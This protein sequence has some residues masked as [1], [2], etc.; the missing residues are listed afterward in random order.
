MAT[1]PSLINLCFG[2][3]KT[4]ILYGNDDGILEGIYELPVELFDGL[5]NQLPALALH[6]LQLLMPSETLNNFHFESDASG[7]GRKR[8]RCD[9]FDIAWKTLFYSR[10]PE[11]VKHLKET[12]LSRKH[13]L[14]CETICDWKQKYWELHLQNC[15]DAVAERAMLPSFKGCVGE[16]KIPGQLIKVIGYEE[17]AKG[18][19]HQ[20]SRFHDHCQEFGCYVRFLRLQN[21]FCNTEA[22]C[23]LAKSKLKGLLLR[24]ISSD[25]HLDG[26]R[27]ILNQNRETI[28]SLEFV[29]CKISLAFLET[30][31]CTLAMEGKQMH[32]VKHFAVKAS[33]F[34]EAN[35]DSLPPQLISFLSSRSL[36][37]LSL[38]DDQIG[39]NFAK[40][41]FTALL[42]AS[43]ALSILELSDNNISGWLSDFHCNSSS[44][45][46]SL[47]ETSKSLKSLRV[48]NLRGNNLRKNDMEDLRCALIHMPVLETLDLA[49]N[50]IEDDGIKCLIPYFV[51]SSEHFTLANLN[52]KN[53]ELSCNGV[54]ELL[55]VL[56][57]LNYHLISLSLADNALGSQIAPLLGD[58]MHTSI[59]SLDIRDIGLGSSGFLEL[60]INMPN[61]VKLISIDI[62]ENR[63]GIQAAEFLEELI[64]RAPELVE[65]YA[66]YNLMP[67]ESLKIIYSALK[68][69]KG[70]LQRI[71]L[72][73]NQ[74]L[75]QA[76]H[77]SALSEFQRHGE[78]IVL[79]PSSTFQDGPYDD[80][81]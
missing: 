78:P 61:V 50:Y 76:D 63:G 19:M 11:L 39:R 33:K 51:K 29:N 25:M 14:E 56:I 16:V 6:K 55:E 10:W 23:L 8:A 12:S 80:D 13:V 60:R 37:S 9:K 48:L 54:T 28:T 30:I 45:A 46:L 74:K 1:P 42:D 34:S 81:P 32:G 24:R 57:A 26:L 38:S 15:F 73:G 31:C 64:S 71:E 43:S 53:C 75:W 36:Q 79:I 62:S 58:L 35:L 49:D 18:S 69:A 77:V 67:P 47:C 4:Q 44:Q 20:F 3:L 65:V 52:L 40:S 70:T 22:L 17:P 72:L 41:T 66:G 27:M 2:A 68:I 59:K 21:I 5:L 7:N